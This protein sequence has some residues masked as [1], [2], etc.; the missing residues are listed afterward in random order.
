MQPGGDV[1]CLSVAET[2]H[3]RKGRFG[4]WV[5]R[6]GCGVQVVSR[7]AANKLSGLPGAFQ[8]TEVMQQVV[9]GFALCSP[10]E[11]GLIQLQSLEQVQYYRVGWMAI[12]AQSC[13]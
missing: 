13:P 2:G 5:F 4:W 10:R 3:W 9:P 8:C 11:I 6:I 12:L 7:K 1:M